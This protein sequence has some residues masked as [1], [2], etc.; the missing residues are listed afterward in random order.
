MSAKGKADGY[1]KTVVFGAGRV[2]IARRRNG[3]FAL[4]WREVGT[5]RRT[6]RTTEKLALEWARAKA[7]DLDTGTG[8][9]WVSAGAA[10]ALAALVE[11]A[12]GDDDGAVRRLLGD[13]RGALGWLGGKA[14]LTVAARWYAE[15]GPLQVQQATL[16]EAVARFLK[17]YDG[18]SKATRQTFGQELDAFL[19]VPENKGMMLMAVDGARLAQWVARKV[20]KDAPAPRTLR[21]RITTWVTFLN[22]CRDWSLLAAGKH[23]ADLLRKPVIPDAGKEILSVD[24][25]A[26]LLAAVR[27]KAQKLEAFLLIGGWLGLRPSEIQRLCWDGF[28][29]DRGYL[30]VSHQVAGKTSS[31]RYVP[32]DARLLDLL[33]GVFERGGKKKPGAK[34]CGFRSREFLSVLARAE[35]ILTVW[36]VDVL[37]HS[38]CSYRIAVV[39]SLDQVAEEAG[40]SPAILKSNYRRPLREED[41]VAW[42]DVV[43]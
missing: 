34:V 5:T 14:D 17:E 21:N 41:G 27:E 8:N 32:V 30:H 18:G 29:W 43:G 11:L 25:G 39:K 16:A 28:E 42:W 20:G 26:R 19:G 12:T 31:E 35:G 33:K 9:R 10:D 1:P 2:R 40:N 6:T 37:R 7:E 24:Q 3:K 4:C 38:F 22:R 15:H 13:V 23:A 36:P